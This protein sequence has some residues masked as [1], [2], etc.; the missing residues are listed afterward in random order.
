MVD[1]EKGVRRM[2]GLELECNL[3]KYGY[4]CGLVG[5]PWGEDEKEGK[6]GWREGVGE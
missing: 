3:T 5:C 1:E 2:R 4:Y 6:R